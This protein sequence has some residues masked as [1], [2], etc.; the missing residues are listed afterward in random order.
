MNI[1]SI[2]LAAAILITTSL[3]AQLSTSMYL[4]VGPSKDLKSNSEYAPRVVG[5]R[6]FNLQPVKQRMTYTAGFAVYKTFPSQF[7]IGAE[8]QYQSSSTEYAFWEISGDSEYAPAIDVVESEH[9]ILLPVS[10][11]A[12]IW[13]FTA[14]TGVSANMIVGK[15]SDFDQFVSFNDTG[16]KMYMGWHAGLGYHLGP[17]EIEV[18]YTQDFRNY[19]SGYELAEKDMVFYGNRNRWLLLVK[20]NLLYKS[21]QEDIKK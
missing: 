15:S 19:G 4:G 5:D 6:N 18:R 7:L 2:L 14:Y 9:S 3:T 20:Y 10:V 21:T 12:H 11:G 1:R 8:L 17:V 16:S 13:N